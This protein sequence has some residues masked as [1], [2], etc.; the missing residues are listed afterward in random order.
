[1]AIGLKLPIAF[2]LLQPLNSGLE[3]GVADLLVSAVCEL[4]S[5]LCFF[6]GLNLSGNS[7]IVSL[8]SLLNLSCPSSSSLDGC[9]G[10]VGGE[11][12]ALLDSLDGGLPTSASLLADDAPFLAFYTV[13]NEVFYL[14]FPS[15]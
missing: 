9:L 13:V 8:L 1:M 2:L 5:G 11:S 6:L 7:G 12:P 10:G 4:L 15:V 14:C 3:F